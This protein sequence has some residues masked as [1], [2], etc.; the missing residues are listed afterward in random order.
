MQNLFLRKKLIIYAETML[1][2]KFDDIEDVSDKQ[3]LKNSLDSDED[4]DEINEDAYNIM[5][6]DDIEGIWTYNII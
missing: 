1:K 6:E 3:P 5:N 4:D 2:R